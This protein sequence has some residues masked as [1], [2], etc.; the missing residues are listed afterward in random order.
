MCRY[1]FVIFLIVYLVIVESTCPQTTKFYLDC[2]SNQTLGYAIQRCL[3]YGMTLVNMSNSS[4]LIADINLLNQTLI[5]TDCTSNFWF[6]SGNLTGI[7]A[8][9]N[10]L[11]QVLTDILS[12]LL[13][14]L[15]N[16]VGAVINI[17]TCLLGICPATTTPPPITHAIIICTRPLQQQ[18]IQKCKTPPTRTDMQT[19]QFQKQPMYGGVLN[20]FPSRSLTV[21]SGICSSTDQCIGISYINE[22]C[23]LYI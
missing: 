4:D 5:S 12:G 10:S 16:T 15:G 21:C 17:V 6:S 2:S 9:V 18:V 22:T 23:N 8:N 11:G 7:V 13:G 14:S 19:F 1:F 20:S 3:Q